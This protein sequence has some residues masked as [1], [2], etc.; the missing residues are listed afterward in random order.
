[1]NGDSAAGPDGF[2]GFFC[3]LCCKIIKNDLYYTISEF[4]AG[5][6]LLKPWTNTILLPVPKVNNF[7]SF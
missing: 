7:T 5:G 2:N 6:D 1:M 4:F 3:I